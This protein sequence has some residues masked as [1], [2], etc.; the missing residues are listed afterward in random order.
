MKIRQDKIFTGRT[1][2]A[3][4]DRSQKVCTRR[5]NKKKKN[6]KKERERDDAAVRPRVGGGV[7][8]VEAKFNCI[9]A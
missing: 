2:F 9:C 6:E 7:G 4:T 8:K 3:E 5:D 1:I